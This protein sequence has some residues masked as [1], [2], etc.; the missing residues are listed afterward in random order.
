[1]SRT[2]EVA[3]RVSI[4]E[5]RTLRDLSKRVA[6]IAQLPIQDERIEFW[7]ALNSLTPVRTMV[8]ATPEEGWHELM[9]EGDLECKN[10]LCREWEWALRWK[11]FRHEHIHDDYPISDFFDVAWVAR[12][13][14]YGVKE[15]QIRAGH[16]GPGTYK[17]DPPIKSTSDFARMRP[18]RIVVDHDTTVRHLDLARDVLG[19]IL[20]VREQGETMCRNMLTRQLIH[21]RGYDQFLIDMHENPGLLH[22]MMS[23]LRDEK[24]RE[25][26]LYEREGVLS[27]NNGPDHILGSGGVACLNQLPGAEFEGHVRMKDMWCF[28]ESQ[29]TIG[30]SPQ[31]F[32]EYVLQYQLPLMEHFALVDYGCCEPLDD[33]FD[34]LIEHIPHLRWLAVHPWADRARAAEKIGDRYVYAYKPHPSTISGPKPDYASAEKEIRETLSIAADCCVSLTLKGTL[35]F[36]HEPQRLTRWIDMAQRVV[37]ET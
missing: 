30:V 14:G 6:E 36:Y 5:R 8:L 33:R 32:F 26:R 35:T 29:E 21:L 25:W 23:F 37:A 27:L 28:G 1:M 10:P 7:R 31:H 17:V 3:T 18:R 34:V 2:S 22:D 24:L 19:D 20:R 11:I 16:G 13:S 12:V 9:S 15:A 4:Q